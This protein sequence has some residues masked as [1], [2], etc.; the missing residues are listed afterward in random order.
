ME[1]RDIRY[2][3]EYRYLRKSRR[4]LNRTVYK[5]TKLNMILTAI[6]IFLIGFIIIAGSNMIVKNR[7][8]E[9]Q[10]AEAN[11]TLEIAN[12]TNEE[13]TENLNKLSDEY[14][15][16]ATLSVTLDD[17]NKSLVD[18][19]N[20]LNKTLDEY[21]EREELFDKYEYALIREDGTRT[22]ITYE[23]I[24]NL[25]N[26]AEELDMS[27]DSICLILSVAMV[28]SQGT[29]TA[30]NTSS[31]AV[32]LGQILSDTGKFVWTNLMDNDSKYVHSTVASDGNTNLQMMAY[33]LNYLNDK[34]NGNTIKV[35]KEYRGENDIEY[36]EK[37][38]TYLDTAG[39]SLKNLSISNDS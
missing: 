13:L 15:K 34:Y 32:G 16:V 9:N 4:A 19:I 23:E 20:S 33:L 17:Q 39:L 2:E 14:E 8:L 3:N 31:T 18:Q 29:E 12:D 24:Q 10:L 11:S 26:T 37:I 1:T 7:D 36:F 38:D 35:I 21:E 22:D 5:L 27:E 28:E 6:V 25:Y 30:K